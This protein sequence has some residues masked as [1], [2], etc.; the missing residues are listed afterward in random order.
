MTIGTLTSE[1]EDDFGKFSVSEPYAHAQDGK[2]VLVTV[3]VLS[4]FSGPFP[5]IG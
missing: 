2:P 5:P 4:T 3:V 1:D